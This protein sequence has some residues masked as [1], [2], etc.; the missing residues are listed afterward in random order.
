M[1]SLYIDSTQT[2]KNS[3]HTERGLN[4]GQATFPLAHCLLD[5]RIRRPQWAL[6]R[7]WGSS[8]LSDAFKLQRAM[9]GLDRVSGLHR[10]VKKS[11]KRPTM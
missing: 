11:A 10:A 2:V 9:K 6:I 1:A 5:V 8:Q 4:I 7:A 3:Q